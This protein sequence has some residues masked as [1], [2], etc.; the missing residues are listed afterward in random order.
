[1][2]CGSRPLLT[3]GQ[4]LHQLPRYLLG[5]II[6]PYGNAGLP[7]KRYVCSGTNFTLRKGLTVQIRQ[8]VQ[9]Y[10]KRHGMRGLNP[11]RVVI[12]VCEAIADVSDDLRAIEQRLSFAERMQRTGRVRY[13]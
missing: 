3:W 11:W 5:A 12:S 8:A 7:F 4:P 2:A 13:R 10:P 9:S 6:P 1:M